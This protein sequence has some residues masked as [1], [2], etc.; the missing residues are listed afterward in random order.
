MGKKRGLS[1]RVSLDTMDYWVGVAS[2]SVVFSQHTES[3]PR[4]DDSAAVRRIKR[5]RLVY[6]Q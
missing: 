1:E 3:E 4:D 2:V 5:R 6:R